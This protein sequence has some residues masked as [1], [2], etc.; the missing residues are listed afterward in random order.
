MSFRK[1]YFIIGSIGEKSRAPVQ[2]EGPLGWTI[3][4]I[5]QELIKLQWREG[6]GMSWSVQFSFQVYRSL[7]V[8]VTSSA[9]L[10]C[11]GYSFREKR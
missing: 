11:T 8:L 10:P 9:W 7:E 4:L 5:T 2:Q 3:G 6:V 1:E